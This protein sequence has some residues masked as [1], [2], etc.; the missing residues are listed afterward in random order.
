MQFK[1]GL[2]LVLAVVAMLVL[3]VDAQGNN[4]PRGR[5]GNRSRGRNKRSINLHSS[6]DYEPVPSASLLRGLNLNAL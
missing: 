3:N 4:C 6:Q 2:I 1:F 5:R